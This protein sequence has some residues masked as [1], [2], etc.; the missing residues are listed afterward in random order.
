MEFADLT[1]KSLDLS[2]KYGLKDLTAE[3]IREFRKFLEKP[4]NYEVA[5]DYLISKLGFNPDD[6]DEIDQALD[7]YKKKELMTG[8]DLRIDNYLCLMHKS[9]DPDEYLDCKVKNS[10][11]KIIAELI[12]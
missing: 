1:F 10:S 12:S 11:A 6:S 5:M 8:D 2:A 3:G 7:W 9:I 4:E